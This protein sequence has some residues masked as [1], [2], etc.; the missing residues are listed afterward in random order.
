[1]PASAPRRRLLL[2]GLGAAAALGVI[3]LGTGFAIGSWRQEKTDDAFVEGHLALVGAQVAGRVVDV[4]VVENQVVKAGDVL[5]RLDTADFEARVAKAR[6]DLDAAVNRQR[7]AAAAAAAAE[8]EGRMAAADLRRAEQDLARTQNLFSAGVGSQQKL[9]EALAQSDSAR[10]RVASLA[11]RAD[12]ERSV[13]GN[14]A[15]VRQA[16]A[17]LESAQLDLEHA[18]IVAPFDG[19]VGRKSV[20]VGSLVTPGQPLLALTGEEAPWVIANFKETQIQHM[21]PGAEAEVR[22]DAFPGVVWKGRVESIAPA[23][24]AK[25]A[26]LPPDNATGNFTKVVQR[27]PV[28]IALDGPAQETDAALRVGLSVQARVD[29]GR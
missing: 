29:V 25:Y 11:S 9:D 2:L 10:A 12:A 8:A 16:E 26:L 17:A 20:E 3:A 28:K 19:T 1:M 15:P 13:L 18:T 7:G 6:A 5:V 22:V 14:D 21:R 23:T 4:A 24:G 27:V